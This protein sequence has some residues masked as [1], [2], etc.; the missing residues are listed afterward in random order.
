MFTYRVS[1]KLL[2]ERKF[3]FLH[4]EMI[5]SAGFFLNDR[6]MIQIFVLKKG[7]SQILFKRIKFDFDTKVLFFSNF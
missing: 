3:A 2:T 1:Q 5:N 7:A 6:G 4:S